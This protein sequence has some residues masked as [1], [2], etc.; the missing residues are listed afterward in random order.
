MIGTNVGTCS[1]AASGK[2][3]ALRN[4]ARTVR[5]RRRTK[6]EEPALPSSR[7]DIQIPLKYSTT[8]KG[9][10]FLLYDSGMG[11]VN[12]ILVFGTAE[13]LEMFAREDVWFADGTFKHCPLLF[14]QIYSLHVLLH[15][16]A[17]PGIY[18]LLPNKTAKTYARLLTA[19][20]ELQPAL[21]PKLVITDFEKAAMKAF[22]KVFPLA[23]LHGC[24]FHFGQAIF[25]RIQQAGLQKRYEN[26]ADFALSMKHLSALA[27]VPTAHVTEAFDALIA[28]HTI[29]AAAREI[30]DY[31][32]DTWIGRIT[33][34]GRRQ[35][36]FPLELW[37]CAESVLND[38]PRTNNSV[39]AWHRGFEALTTS[40]HENLWRCISYF[41]KSHDSVAVTVEQYVAGQAPPAKKKK[42]TDVNN[43]LKNIVNQFQEFETDADAIEYLRG[44]AHNIRY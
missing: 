12:R 32:E 2:L 5:R 17:I 13:T 30:L 7:Q 18:A 35:P 34:D 6:N 29:P 9:H 4:I 21:N 40:H 15:G 31:M 23:Q 14:Y 38:L 26:D 22:L 28:E 3:P 41:Q 20:H 25:R 11:D 43:R 39:E 42:Y 10:N 1:Q 36:I 37:N 24:F 19:L 27:F 44:I 33:R 8:A 16:Q